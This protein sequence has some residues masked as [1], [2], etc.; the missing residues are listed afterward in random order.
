MRWVSSQRVP[1]VRSVKGYPDYKG[2]LGDLPLLDAANLDDA[3][4][5]KLRQVLT[6]RAA[7][8][9]HMPSFNRK[10]A[11]SEEAIRQLDRPNP[12][13]EMIEVAE[14]YRRAPAG[15]APLDTP[16]QIECATWYKLV[17]PH[18]MQWLPRRRNATAAASASTTS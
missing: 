6:D 1:I 18:G 7:W 5:A 8:E 15:A 2:I 10:L 9:Q 11:P 3:F 14:R 4:D 16:S 13:C 12:H 17:T